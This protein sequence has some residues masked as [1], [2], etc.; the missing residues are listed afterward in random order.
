[1]PILD[2]SRVLSDSVTGVSNTDLI[3]VPLGKTWVVSLLGG[4]DCSKSAKPS[5]YRLLWGSGN[6]FDTV[7]V[8]CL[9][10]GT[11]QIVLKKDFQGDGVK[12]LRMQREN[13]ENQAKEMPFWIEAYER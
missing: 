13:T 11:Q 9:T 1:M 4:T 5:I 7:R 8:I 12:F 3:P 10:T 6:S 2:K